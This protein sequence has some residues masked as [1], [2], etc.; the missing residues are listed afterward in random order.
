[1]TVTYVKKSP[2]AEAPAAEN[3]AD[4]KRAMSGIASPYFD[5][6]ASIRVGEVIYTRGGGNCTQDQLAAWLEYKSIK[7]G[8]FLTR[9]AAAKAF[10]IVQASGGRITV[11]DRGMSIIAPVM[12]EDAAAAKVVAFLGVP[13]FARVYDQ[14]RGKQLPPEV[15]LKNLFKSAPYS[16]LPDRVDPAVRVFLNSAEQ[17]GFFSTTGGDRSRLIEPAMG[18]PVAKS[19]DGAND[20]GSTP[21][22]SEKPKA[23]GGGGGPSGGGEGTAGVHS[24][25]VGLLRDLPPPGTQWEPNKK[26]RF[27]AAFQATIDHI[28]PED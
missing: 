15:G 5:L 6:D 4:S 7:S 26:K 16:I 9:L 17:A 3:A 20:E 25:I 14:F 22:V 2:N 19:A 13:L 21:A 28:Y 8:T 23:G 10:G 1:M 24:A 27:L 18:A 12:P 11:T